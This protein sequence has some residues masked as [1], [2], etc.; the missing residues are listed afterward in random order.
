M[1]N[2]IRILLIDDHTLFRES[3]VRLLAVEPGFVVVGHCASVSEG[4][5]LLGS[6]EIDVV[7]LD[8][9]LGEEVGT[10]LLQELNVSNSAVRILMVTAGM[11]DSVTREVLSAG[12]SGVIYK[13]SG[14]GMLI[15]A[16]SKVAQGEM[17]LDSGA[18]RSLVASRDKPDTSQSVQPLTERQ[19][20]V[21]HGILD[22]LTNKEIASKLQVS[23]SSIKAV[24]QELFHKAGARTRSQLVRIAIEK[25]SKN[26]LGGPQ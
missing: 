1:K 26:W 7:L 4:T 16:I 24:I 3:L 6:T 5:T 22:G 8:Y 18:I 23:E 21:L 9:D 19:R 15:E 25:H 2:P 10:D 13:H 14:P 11:R 17:W 12:V 20:E